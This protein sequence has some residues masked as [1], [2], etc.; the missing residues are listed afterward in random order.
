M[1]IAYADSAR[2]TK[3][4][5]KSTVG[6]RP[7]SRRLVRIIQTDQSAKT[8]EANN[9]GAYRQQRF[10]GRDVG[11]LFGTENAQD[12]IV[13]VNWFPEITPLLLIPPVGIRVAELA[14]YSGRVGV[15]SILE[16]TE[17]ISTA[18]IV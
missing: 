13:L 18:S 3:F 6:K 2:S 11:V 8:E 4:F 12:I 14:L 1:K 5:F 7:R 17:E 9:K 10:V 15:V 16:S